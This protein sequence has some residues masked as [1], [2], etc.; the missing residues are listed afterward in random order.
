[1]NRLHDLLVAEARVWYKLWSSWLAVLWGIIIT[2]VWNDPSLLLSIVDALPPQMRG[3]LSPV[4]LASVTALP[5]I[6]RLLK[7]ARSES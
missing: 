6:V 5:I 7:Q 1:M 2:L 4:V 3:W